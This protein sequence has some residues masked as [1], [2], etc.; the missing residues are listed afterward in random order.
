MGNS[1]SIH[2]YISIEIIGRG[3]FGEVH[4]VKNKETNEIYAIKVLHTEFNKNLENYM[5]ALNNEI[6]IYSKLNHPCILPF[7]GASYF[8]FNDELRPAIVVKY[9]VNGSLDH[10]LE[11]GKQYERIPFWDSTKI[12]HYVVFTGYLRRCHIYT[13]KE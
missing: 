12:L 6:E 1:S 10:L 5:K 7:I 11:Y 3:S 9:A 2:N 13:N 4:K 8:S